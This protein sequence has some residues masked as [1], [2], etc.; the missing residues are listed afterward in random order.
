MPGFIENISQVR[1]KGYEVVACVSVNDGRRLITLF[2]HNFFFGNFS[3]KL[4]IKAFVTDAWGKATPGAEGA[5]VRMLADPLA[6]FTK[7]INMDKD[8]PPLGGVRSKRYTALIEDNVVKQLFEE[9][10]GTISFGP[11][12]AL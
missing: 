2:W 12:T 11:I 5:G 8:I 9:P 6:T 1:A 7:A 3:T 10:D 4:Y